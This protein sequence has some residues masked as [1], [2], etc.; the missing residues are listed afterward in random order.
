MI[1]IWY[2]ESSTSIT[3]IQGILHVHHSHNKLCC[4]MCTCCS[5]AQDN[6]WQLARQTG[7]INQTRWRRRRLGLNLCAP[8]VQRADNLGQI[9]RQTHTHKYT[10]NNISY[11]SWLICWFVCGTHATHSV[12]YTRRCTSAESN[13]HRLHLGHKGCVRVCVHREPVR[14]M[15]PSETGR[16]EPERVSWEPAPG[17][18]S[19]RVPRAVS[20]VDSVLVL[21]CRL[22]RRW[23][24]H[25]RHWC[26]A[27]HSTGALCNCF[28]YK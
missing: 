22:Q 6:L 12:K 19:S 10:Y 24:T 18:V 26:T 7:H 23:H 11:I 3:H 1:C 2:K 25:T 17:R 13:L 9:C 27:L 21:S 4:M 8:K 14:R 28:P 5:I 15:R 16:G 20:G